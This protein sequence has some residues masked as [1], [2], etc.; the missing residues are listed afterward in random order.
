MPRRYDWIG[1]HN[2]CVWIHIAAECNL[3]RREKRKE[4]G[5]KI[6]RHVRLTSSLPRP[7]TTQSLAERRPRLPFLRRTFMQRPI[8]FRG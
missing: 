7:L 5:E 6:A 2:V 3:S 8:V 4:E 1:L